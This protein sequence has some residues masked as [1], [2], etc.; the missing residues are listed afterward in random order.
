MFLQSLAPLGPQVIQELNISDYITRLASSLG[1]DTEGLIKTDEQKQLEQ[2]AAQAKQ[3][4]MMNQQMM[5]KMAEK[6]TPELMRGLNEA[7]DEGQAPPPEM[8]N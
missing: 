8:T 6:G 1:I 3:A 5:G 2:Q 4:E 7:P